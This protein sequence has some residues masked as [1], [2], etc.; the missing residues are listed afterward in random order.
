MNSGPLYQYEF[1]QY[2]GYDIH[3]GIAEYLLTYQLMIIL[4][5]PL[6]KAVLGRV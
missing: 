2:N 4:L 6:V 5:Y 1:Q 3:G